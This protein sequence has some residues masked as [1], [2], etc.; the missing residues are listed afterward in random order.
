MRATV[1]RVV[2]IL[3]A[4]GVSTAS[5]SL[6]PSGRPSTGGATSISV[7]AGAVVPL[8][9]SKNLALALLAAGTV[10]G[11]VWFLARPSTSPSAS[12]VS[13]PAPAQPVPLSPAPVA[14]QDVVPHAP[15]A[16]SPM[17]APSAPAASTTPQ[18]AIVPPT[19]GGS[20]EPHARPSTVGR[21]PSRPAPVVPSAPAP[22]AREATL[23][24]PTASTAPAAPPVASVATPSPVVPVE[25]RGSKPPSAPWVVDIVEQRK[26]K[27]GGAE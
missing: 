27:V 19:S 2:R 1:A 6:P 12:A 14:T 15:S 20:S 23:T 11:L 16:A 25:V 8:R 24:A 7:H 18:V 26:G 22:P 3:E 21:I 13:L 5:L 10:I 17:V 9:G 4:P